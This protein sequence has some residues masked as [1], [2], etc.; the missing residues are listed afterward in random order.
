TVLFSLLY[1]GSCDDGPTEPENEPGRRDYVWE[2]DTLKIDQNDIMSIYEIWGSSPD[3]IWVGGYGDTYRNS[4]WHYN[5][6][7]WQKHIRSGG[8]DISGFFGIDQNNIW[9]VTG[10]NTIWKYNGTSWNEIIHFKYVGYD[11]VALNSIDGFSN[12]EIY[13]V[14]F[15][16]N[17]FDSKRTRIIMK[18]DGTSWSFV[19]IPELDEVFGNVYCDKYE[20]KIF[21]N[22]HRE[23]T[24]NS[25]SYLYILEGDSLKQIINSSDVISMGK[26]NG[27]VYIVEKKKIYNYYKNQLR[28]VKDFSNTNFVGRIWGR[29]EKDFFC[30]TWDF[31]IAHYNGTDLVDIIPISYDYHVGDGILFE[32]DVFLTCENLT[33]GTNFIIHGK[34]K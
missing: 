10:N 17:F 16:G 6:I 3:N 33:T 28:L 34:L 23:T 2:Y 31:T 26:I 11:A 7:N 21:I 1:L 22:S 18:F 5:G 24:P 14:G 12:S 4:L 30:V 32:K 27:R 15:A 13:A 9:M 19:N 25:P 29:S 20:K 8:G